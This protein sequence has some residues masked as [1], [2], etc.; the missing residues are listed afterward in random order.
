MATTERHAEISDRFLQQAEV[1]LGRGD[2]LQASEK[3]WGAVVHHVKSVARERNWDNGSHRDVNRAAR[4]LIRLT[5]DP[6]VNRLRF[7]AMNTLHVNFYEENL[8]QEDVEAMVL[9]ARVLL[10]AM[11]AVDSEGDVSGGRVE[12]ERE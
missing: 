3:A 11:R 6:D 1:E 4:Q 2:L 5:S 7:M 8:D 12:E 9:D 10:E